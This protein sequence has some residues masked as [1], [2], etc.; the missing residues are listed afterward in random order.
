MASEP[1]L[2]P[3]LSEDASLHSQICPGSVSDGPPPFVRM[4]SSSWHQN[5]RSSVIIVCANNLHYHAVHEVWGQGWAAS[6]EYTPQQCWITDDP[7]L[8]CTT[9]RHRPRARVRIRL[10]VLMVLS[11]DGDDSVLLSWSACRCHQ[12]GISQH[13]DKSVSLPRWKYFISSQLQG[14]NRSRDKI[15]KNHRGCLACC[16]GAGTEIHRGT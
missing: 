8:W 9:Q 15:N 5:T 6:G 11:D 2:S 7:V 1:D 14:I 3:V 10:S 16:L 4:S 13:R 12:P